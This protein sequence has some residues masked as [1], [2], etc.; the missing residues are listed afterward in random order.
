MIKAN[1]FREALGLTQEETAMVLRISMSQLSMFE[2]G[3]R[4]LPIEA[5][6]KLVS[7]YNYVQSKQQEKLEHP[8]SIAEKNKIIALLKQELL[9]SQIQQIVLERKI[10]GCTNKY[11]KSI[12]ALQLCEYLQTKLPEEGKYQNDLV[13]MIR[14]KALKG[15]EKNGFSEQTKLN[16]NLKALQL[17]QKELQMELNKYK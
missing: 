5:K 9:K 13:E 16:L 10:K 14:N 12:S 1:N 17:H 15:I 3:Q 4:D 6:L 7:M 2:I 8:V 11:Q